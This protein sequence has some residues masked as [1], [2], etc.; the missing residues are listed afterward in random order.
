MP[1][2]Q[3]YTPSRSRLLTA[4]IAA[5]LAVTAGTLV[6][7]PVAVAGTPAVVSAVTAEAPIAFPLASEV[8]SAGETGFLS[9]SD[10]GEYRWTRL[11]DGTTSDLG[12]EEVLGAASDV[13]VTRPGIN[14]V[15]LRDMATGAAPVDIWINMLGGGTHTPIGAVGGTVLT[16]V[17]P[18]AGGTVLHLV[19][20]EADGSTGN[21]AVTGLPADASALTFAAGI[22]GTALVGYKSG[23]TSHFAVVDLATRAV[24]GTYDNQ[25]PVEY[26]QSAAVSA[27]HVAW[28]QHKP[29]S[30]GYFDDQ[31]IVVE[32]RSGQAATLNT[33]GGA[34]KV[35][36]V[37]GWVV[38]GEDETDP[39]QYRNR[40]RAVSLTGTSGW[41]PW[42]DH[43]TSVT[44]A[45][46]GSLL[47][48][49]GSVAAGEGEG[50]YRVR[51]GASVTRELVAGTGE[52]TGVSVT[53]GPDIPA[54]LDLDKDRG[55]VPFT[56]EV[57]RRNVRVSVMISKAET[58]LVTSWE[59]EFRPTEGPTGPGPVTLTWQ[60]NRS[61]YEGGLT[62]W[63]DVPNGD[64]VW[65]ISVTPLDGVGKGVGLSGKMKV[66]RAPK[67]HDFSDNGS[68][69]LFAVDSVS[70]DVSVFEGSYLPL[71]QGFNWFKG[72]TLT[73]WG[74]TY[75]RFV[76]PGD[77]GGMSTA[78]E[79]ITRDKSGGL[80]MHP[81]TGS[82]AFAPR[83]KIGTGWQIY[84]EIVGG[85]DLTGDGRPDVLATDTAGGLWL[86]PATGNYNAPLGARKQI[87]TGWG[88][89]NQI[90]ATGNI[91]GA[92]AGDLVARD[93]DGVLWQYLGKGDGT[94]APRT[95]IGTGWNTYARIVG[96]GDIDR[97]GRNDLVAFDKSDPTARMYW[98]GGTGDWQAPF[99]PRVENY[100]QNSMTDRDWF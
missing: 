42:I 77:F 60:G 10:A 36:L 29:R 32:R 19:T 28:V 84:N 92:P 85:S 5:S 1:R 24:T 87:G 49:G 89:Y 45:P 91:A 97:D 72:A 90:T 44:A 69:D 23:G 83:V 4:A 98:Y 73:G 9:K 22:P 43:V 18:A 33:G 67:S 95:K 75:D 21:H 20:H 82:L 31:L 63:G 61:A 86:Y 25:G 66:V 56:I 78:P 3:H 80:W 13:V 96:T 65:Q 27:T 54:V 14:T 16:S 48:R 99:K 52:K 93:K 7:A 51:G 68:P 34:V 26:A 76:A 57:S 50:L 94:F 88:V 100:F 81:G 58:P 38:Y 39:F 47:V 55:V 62:P 12:Q 35:G 30:D 8:V 53:A 64:Y 46:D 59:S 17:A 71:Q 6:A 11:A 37:D 70:G 79:L 40:P 74:G 15:R 2:T 41:T